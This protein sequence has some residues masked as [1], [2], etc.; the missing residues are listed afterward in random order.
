MKYFSIKEL[1]KSSLAKKLNIDNT[2]SAEIEN[3]L[4][5]LIEE[6]LDPIREA[7]GS[8]IMTTSGYR[9]AQ[10]N[11]ACGGSP[12]S[13]HKEGYAA[14]LDTD[15]N[16]KL[17]NTIVT[18]DFKWTQLIL[19]YPEKD[20]TPSWIHISYNPNNLKCEIL[21]CN[22]GKYKHIERKEIE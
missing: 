22:N 2:P 20:G 15:Q 8:P 1:C 13:D 21:E 4:T 5:V 7:F 12:T 10:L 19:E 16:K 11:A 17:W 14:D 6:C 3:N 9:C 18:G